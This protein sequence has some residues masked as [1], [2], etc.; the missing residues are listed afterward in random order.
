MTA[1]ILPDR[2]LTAAERQRR[3]REKNKNDPAWK[4]R[5]AAEYKRWLAG[6]GSTPEQKERNRL[7]KLAHRRKN[8]QPYRDGRNRYNAECVALYQELSGNTIA[9]GEGAHARYIGMKIRKEL[10]K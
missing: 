3:Y 8:P 1:R 9:R 4:E 7:R 2:P 10:R 6:K 5:R